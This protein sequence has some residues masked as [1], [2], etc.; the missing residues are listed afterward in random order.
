[1]KPSRYN[2]HIP[3]E[4]DETIVYNTLSDSRVIV[5]EELLSVIN[6]CEMIGYND[7]LR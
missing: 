2:V 5:T 6:T 1:M 3:I 7:V 4:H